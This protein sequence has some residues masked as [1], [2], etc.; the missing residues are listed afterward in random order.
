[1]PE[2]RKQFSSEFKVW[3]ALKA[4]KGQKTAEETSLAF[5]LPAHSLM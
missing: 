5:Q 3:I 4:I 2:I 1:M